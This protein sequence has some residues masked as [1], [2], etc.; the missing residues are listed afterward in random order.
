MKTSFAAKQLIEAELLF[1]KRNVWIASGS[2]A[3]RVPRTECSVLIVSDSQL[4]VEWLFD[5]DEVEL[6]VE[7]PDS[8]VR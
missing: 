5:L 8:K 4:D 2:F 1:A 3:L 7:Q 6:I